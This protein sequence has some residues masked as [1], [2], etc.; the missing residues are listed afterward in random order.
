VA[1]GGSRPA[2]LGIVLA[3]LMSGGA[4]VAGLPAVAGAGTGVAP[5]GGHV[6][7]ADV[8]LLPGGV[9]SS[10]ITLPITQS[11]PG[12][13]PVASNVTADGRPVEANLESIASLGADVEM[14]IDTSA[15]TT[16]RRAA[17]G[18]I[19]EFVRGLA[20]S[21]RLGLV[22][23]PGESSRVPTD[24]HELVLTDLPRQPPGG[25]SNRLATALGTGTIDPTRP[26]FIVVFSRASALSS[27]QLVQAITAPA[28]PGAVINVVQLADA[29]SP[30][31]AL[32]DFARTSG[33]LA[34]SVND[35]SLLL[36]AFNEIATTL[37]RTYRLTLPATM[38]STITATIEG[39]GAPIPM[40]FVAARTDQPS[41]VRL[42][43]SA[44]DGE[45]A[46]GA[47][48]GAAAVARESTRVGEIFGRLVPLP[49]LISVVLAIG[50]ALVL[51][52]RRR[53]IVTRRQRLHDT[54]LT[55]GRHLQMGDESAALVQAAQ[56]HLM[57]AVF[58]IVGDSALTVPQE[59]VVAAEVRASM[60]LLRA[61]IDQ[62][63]SDQPVDAVTLVVEL[64]DDRRPADVAVVHPQ[65]AEV[66][67][68]D[69]QQIADAL[70]YG[71]WSAETEVS[72]PERA[73]NLLGVDD[74][75]ELGIVD[76]FS[77][78]L[79]PVS[80]A[81]LISAQLDASSIAGSTA[82]AIGRVLS[83]TSVRGV[84]PIGVVPLSVVL[85]DRLTDE[86]STAADPSRPWPDDL[87]SDAASILSALTEAV[88]RL[89]D[90]QAEVNRL[91]GGYIE[92]LKTSNASRAVGLVELMGT[93][94]VITVEDAQRATGLS[95]QG[96]RNHIRRFEARG[97]LVAAE[98]NGPGGRR[99]WIAVEI[100]DAFEAAIHR[101]PGSE[102]DL[103]PNDRTE[104]ADATA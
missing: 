65:I 14:V 59:L 17:Q 72:L 66:G 43:G 24:Q 84:V 64:L 3:V 42:S 58:R 88:V 23:A 52:G 91:C 53:R 2:R 46:V 40:Q 74:V 30:S 37:Q 102:L 27:A 68:V 103:R 10:L 11:A 94:V 63:A 54:A 45:S 26:R 47:T 61:N 19:V 33:G 101:R 21:V 7:H 76:E 77:A 71:L 22:G 93:S 55:N 20:P 82:R 62:P 104:L 1:T 9:I 34:L 56:G 92:E 35:P 95:H 18:A 83:A 70:R 80:A 90:G 73:R 60:S 96:V 97:W 39:R 51:L 85:A 25:A 31:E 6:S 38:G 81:A 8:V 87:A 16:I 12:V 44:G 57:G 32:S 49:A 4:S 41:P 75:S 79:D 13:A 99:R 36:S 98:K 50:L 100:I 5:D 29:A 86:S 78:D 28:V 48:P 89:N 67:A 69:H 15:D